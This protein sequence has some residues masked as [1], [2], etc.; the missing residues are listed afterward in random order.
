VN[1][2][3]TNAYSGLPELFAY[4][5]AK[6]GLL[7]LTRNLARALARDRIRVNVVNPGWV[8]SEGEVAVQARQGH[9]TDWIEAMGRQQPLGRHQRPEDAAAAVVYLASDAASQVTG[10]ELNCDAGRSMPGLTG[11]F[12]AAPAARGQ[13][14][15]PVRYP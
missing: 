4:S 13:G 14:A 11:A 2:G 6:G 7:T 1:I 5:C 9:D 10:V 3:S 12:P 15:A 8:I